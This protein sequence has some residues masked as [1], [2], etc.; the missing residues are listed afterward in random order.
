MDIFAEGKIMRKTVLFLLF[1]LYLLFGA[2]IAVGAADERKGPIREEDY[3]EKIRVACELQ[4]A[5]KTLI[6]LNCKNSLARVG[7]SKILV[8]AAPLC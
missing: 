4:T 6:R 8:L 5:R 1:A 3:P 7:R 2:I